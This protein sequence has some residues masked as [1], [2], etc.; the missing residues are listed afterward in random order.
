[1]STA[2]SEIRATSDIR[3]VAVIGHGGTARLPWRQALVRGTGGAQV[4][5]EWR[6]SS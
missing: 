1:M 6:A 4:P 3:N 2:T 5:P